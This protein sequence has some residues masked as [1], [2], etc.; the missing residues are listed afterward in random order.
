MKYLRLSY[1][2]TLDGP[3]PPGIPSPHLEQISDIARGD[4]SN[5]FVLTLTNHSGTHVDA[6]RHFIVDGLPIG[7]FEPA[8][9]VFARPVVCDVSLGDAEMVQPAH[10]APHAGRIAT[11]DLLL[12]RTGYAARRRD[13]PERYRTVSPG[14]SAAGAR[15]LR[16][17]F[18]ALRGVGLDTVSLACIAHV[19]EGI[20]AHRILL[21]GPGRRFLII[22][23]MN[24]EHDLTTLRQ[25]IVLP[26]LVK[27][28]DSGPCTILGLIES[29]QE[30]GG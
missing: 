11:A 21:G 29:P 22:E 20:E 15:Y 13:D 16:D 6:P 24:L 25:V 2:L 3:L 30:T 8:E 14:F 9:F 7:D 10:L 26:L 28:W 18:P 1:D 23:D 19:A 27:G 5:V 4:V 17:R 12:I